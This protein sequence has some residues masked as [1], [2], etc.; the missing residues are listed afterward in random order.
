MNSA[1]RSGAHTNDR[2]P[3]AFASSWR[4]AG[5]LFAAAAV[6]G[7]A[8][9]TTL[10]SIYTFRTEAHAVDGMVF[11]AAE[12]RAAMR[13][14]LDSGR[15]FPAGSTIVAHVRE[16]AIY[17]VAAVATANLLGLLM[18]AV[19]LNFMNA[20]VASVLGAARGAGTVTRAEPLTTIDPLAPMVTAASVTSLA[21]ASIAPLKSLVS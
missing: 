12:Y 6:V 15:G 11:R 5:P 16:L 18:G 1:S 17:L 2:M 4:V 14:W 8:A 19:L 3:L 7:W 21:S 13:R 20:W 10:T 9:G